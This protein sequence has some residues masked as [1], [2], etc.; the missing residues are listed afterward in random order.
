MNDGVM[1]RLNDWATKTNYYVCPP[2]VF[3]YCG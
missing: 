2:V 1:G 3:L